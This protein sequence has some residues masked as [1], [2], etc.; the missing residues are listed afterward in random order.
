MKTRLLIFILTLT[1]TA[2]LALDMATSARAQGIGL[3]DGVAIT[4]EVV[5]ID[6]VDRTLMLL[7]PEGNIVELE[8]SH[9]A[10]NFDQL[11]VGDQVKVEYYESVALYL[12]ARGQKLEIFAGLVPMQ[13]AKE[14]DNSSDTVVEAVDVSTTVQAI[15]R[16]K[17]TVTLKG[18]DGK[19][20][21]IQVDPSVNTFETLK[22]G[23]AV[24][25]RYT[26]AT[27]ISVETP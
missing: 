13:S 12:G 20:V 9:A 19:S 10:R 24:Y 4:A 16:T 3:G 25:A 22:V 7:G 15:D 1:F 11:E 17:R 8:V 6:R 5:G 23:D 27:A 18:P 21:T 26:E 2:I 14:D